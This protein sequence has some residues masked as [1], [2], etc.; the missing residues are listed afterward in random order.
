MTASGRG[1]ADDN[2]EGG[3]PAVSDQVDDIRVGVFPA[4]AAQVD[5]RRAAVAAQEVFVLVAG[6]F[7][8]TARVDR[9]LAAAAPEDEFLDHQH[10]ADRQVEF[11]VR[12]EFRVRVEFQVDSGGNHRQLHLRVGGQGVKS[13]DRD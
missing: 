11:Q 12:V 2:P 5:V 8:A 7:P 10:R 9:L 6:P 4:A 13:D 3:I 1:A